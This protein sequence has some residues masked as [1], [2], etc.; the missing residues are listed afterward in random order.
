MRLRDLGLSVGVG[1]P[2]QFKAITDVTCVMVGHTTLISGHGRLEPGRGPVRT[3][4]TAS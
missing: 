2:G 1:T 4:V 3:G